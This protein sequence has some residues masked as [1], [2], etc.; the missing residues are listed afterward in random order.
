LGI[1]LLDQNTIN[2][3]AA[4]EVI[5]R[6]S[7]VVK[8][9][10]ENAIDAGAMAITVE[11]KEGG[12]SFIR[13]TDNGSGINK[14][15][16]DI[17]FKRHATSKIKSIE[18]L[19][20]V[21]SL[22]FRGEAL[23]S[24]SAVSQVE[25]ITKTKDS[26]TGTRYIS[27]GGQ[28]MSIEDIGAP[29]GTTF[30]VRNLF[31]NTPVRRK[32]LKSAATEAGYINSLMQYLALSHPDISFRFINNNQ[33]KL[34]TSGNMKLKDIIY[35][36]YGR[37]ITANLYEVNSSAN[38]IKI[39][40][41][42]GKPFV[43]RGNRTYENY[44]IN[45]RYIKSGIINRAIEA[46]YK[47]F[48]MPHNYPFTVLHFT[49][50][51]K[52]I[53]VNVHPTKMELR[54]SDNEYVYNF[55]YDTILSTLKGKELVAKVEADGQ[56]MQHIR[57]DML[58]EG[59][60]DKKPENIPNVN[61]DGQQ[62]IESAVQSDMVKDIENVKNDSS[63]QTTVNKIVDAGMSEGQPA[64]SDNDKVVRNIDNVIGNKAEICPSSSAV[65]LV[66]ESTYKEQQENHNE[67]QTT[68]TP[69]T[70]TR[71]PEPFEVKRSEAMVKDDEKKYQADV[72]AK[73]EQMSM[74]KDKLLDED[75]KNNYRIIGQLFDTY[76]LI[77]FEDRFYM[78]DQHAAHEKV[79]YERMMK[80]IKE[81]HIDTQMIMPPIILTL[82]MNEEEVLKRNMPVFTK[83][84][85]E[86]EE[87]GGNEYKV[88]GIPAG[89]P[90]LDYRQMLMDLIDGLMRE[91]RMSDMD[92]LTEKVA[93]MS[94]KAAI[95]G[96][97]KISY[98]EAKELMKELMKADN[99]YNCPHG[100]P[101]LIVMSKYDIEK[102]FKR[103]V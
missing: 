36:V 100:R 38:N 11:I 75:N 29:D 88:T 53:D 25:L 90:K 14:N 45:G 84:G 87:F 101:T 97:N 94:C 24:I 68:L 60:K 71:L 26:I 18:D 59:E 81:H 74:F 103:I 82:N 12:I 40:G 89:F 2:K 65:T 46:G 99:P 67:V 43:N 47:G 33:N 48:I 1:Q 30:I 66:P 91:G 73:P 34:H 80:K 55:V 37:D 76:W 64:G 69:A 83:M 5:E 10:V 95:K 15:E 28:K 102:K 42:I 51:P 61:N 21:S 23:A 56:V 96:N 22:G 39:E 78:M 4:G 86:I 41:Y 32:F 92:I 79:L 70:K 31:F 54:F 44:Y 3:I 58:D 7:S 35:N 6:P 8:E 27:E 19:I 93:S 85:Y 49:I 63:V 52:I 62:N 50:N 17:A 57:K 77:E 9:L 72:K 98:E 13:V 20:T 16:I